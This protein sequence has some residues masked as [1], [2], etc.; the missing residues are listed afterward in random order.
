MVKSRLSAATQ[1]VRSRNS[2]SALHWAALKP[3]ETP[4]IQ[5]N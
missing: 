4:N 3:G 5:N 2:Q 1:Q